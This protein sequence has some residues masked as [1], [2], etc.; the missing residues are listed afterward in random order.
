MKWGIVYNLSLAA[1]LFLLLSILSA[2]LPLR[3]TRQGIYF[4]DQNGKVV[5]F[6]TGD[7]SK[8][9]VVRTTKSPEDIYGDLKKLDPK[10]KDGSHFEA[11]KLH[12]ISVARYDSVVQLI[13]AGDID[14]QLVK[15]NIVEIES[16]S[17]LRQVIN[18]IPDDGSGGNYPNNNR[19]YGGMIQADNSLAFFEKGPFGNPCTRGLSISIPGDGKAEYHSHP[20]GTRFDIRFEEIYTCGF[21]QAPSQ[22]DMQ[23]AGHRRGYV[24]GMANEL[25][26]VYDSAGIKAIFPFPAS[27]K[28]NSR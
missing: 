26:Y 11:A 22:H 3:H 27:K 2:L 13:S 15:D 8:S 6:E 10:L 17:L 21:M 12:N 16:M 19:E 4:Y 23:A 20:S 9:Y 25:V 18:K 24:F 5:W 28:G 1:L 14:N 7:I